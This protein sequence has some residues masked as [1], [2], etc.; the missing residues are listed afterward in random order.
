MPRSWTLA[1]RTEFSNSL[2]LEFR[3]R[4]SL[5]AQLAAFR[6]TGLGDPYCLHEFR[7]EKG[8]LIAFISRAYVSHSVEPPHADFRQ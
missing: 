7:N 2:A 3:D 1:V 4:S 6:G 5:V 8:V